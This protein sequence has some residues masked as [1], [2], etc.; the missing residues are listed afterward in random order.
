MVLSLYLLYGF[1]GNRFLQLA[2]MLLQPRL[3]RPAAPPSGLSP[4]SCIASPGLAVAC[5]LSACRG[6][7]PSGLTDSYEDD[8]PAHAARFSPQRQRRYSRGAATTGEQFDCPPC[9]PT[10]GRRGA[11]LL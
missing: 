1:F 10:D 8:C 3:R 11:V 9:T 5:G 2:D 7:S 6:L 4:A